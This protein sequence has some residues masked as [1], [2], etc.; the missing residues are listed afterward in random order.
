VSGD[1]DGADEGILLESLPDDVEE[2]IRRRDAWRKQVASANEGFEFIVSDLASWGPA[3]TVRVAF[4]DGDATLHANV[5]DATRQITDACNVTLDFG[6]DQASGQFRRWTVADAE[7][8]ADIRVSFD[9]GGYWS[10]VGTDSSDPTIGGLASP[11]GGD[12]NQR[13]LNLGGFKASLPQQWQGIARHEF[14]HALAFHHAH[15]NMRGTC[16][17]EFRWDDDAGYVPTKNDL[18][19][20]VPDEAGRRPGIYTFLSGEP[21]KWNKAKVD[22]NLRTLDDPEAVAGPFDSDS[23]MLYRFADFFYKNLPSSCAP[24]GNGTDLSQG[25]KRGLRLLYPETPQEIAVLTEPSSRVLEGLDAAGGGL[26]AGGAGSAHGAR[27]LELLRRR[28]ALAG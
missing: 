13:S 19:V 2:S 6:L 23:V 1:L 11:I 9:L 26:E 24:T 10:L 21:N 20:F 5:A 4:L 22:H 18:G 25:D 3:A 28:A 8:A 7:H 27:L 14:L 12:S 16:E 15:Q 17:S